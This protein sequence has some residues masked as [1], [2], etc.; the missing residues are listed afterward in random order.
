[1]KK[2]SILFFLL[3]YINLYAQEK[4]VFIYATIFDKVGVVTDAHIVN[5]QTK[6]GTFSNESGEFR[7]LAKEN[8]SLQVSSVGY[9]T[10][11][12]I[13]KKENF[14]IQK[15]YIELNKIAIELDEVAL[16][17][18]NLLGNLT[19]DSK[20]IKKEKVINAETLK[21]PFAGSRKLSQAERRLHTATTSA[22]GISLDYFLNILSG[23]LKKLKKH[24][25]IE[26]QEKRILILK[27][28]YST[29]ILHEL[30]IKEDD[31]YRFI[32]FSEAHKDCKT[33]LKQGEIAMIYFLKK[34]SEE[35]KLLNSDTYK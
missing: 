19:S 22:Y 26:D 28:N 23:R 35:F 27:N 15:N 5:L 20:L 33:N 24:K 9:E 25:V 31:L 30:K 4:R 3:L 13:A 1:M 29:Y 34:M 16:K 10:T 18:N 2:S 17:K 12:W 11:F 14:G 7:I 21:L 32:Y 6:Q 8:D